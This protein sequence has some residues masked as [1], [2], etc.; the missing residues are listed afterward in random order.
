MVCAV[1]LIACAR[2]D[3]EGP[4]TEGAVGS[5][6]KCGRQPGAAG[7]GQADWIEGMRKKKRAREEAGLT[8]HSTDKA[9]PET[10]CGRVG[11]GGR[12]LFVAAA[13]VG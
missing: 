11:L 6:S 2:R 13:V 10:C 9:V 8:R 12:A 1:Q 3:S 7:R 5:G 4:A